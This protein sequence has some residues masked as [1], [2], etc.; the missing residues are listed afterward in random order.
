MKS[1]CVYD[2][3]Y[4]YIHRLHKLNQIKAC[5]YTDV[6]FHWLPKINGITVNCIPYLET[7][8]S[9]A[10]QVTGHSAYL[11]RRTSGYI[12]ILKYKSIIFLILTCHSRSPDNSLCYLTPIIEKL[13]NNYLNSWTSR[14]FNPLKNVNFISSFRP[15]YGPGVDLVSNRNE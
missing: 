14:N 10:I 12:I 15:R 5:R 7:P 8:S 4:I 9:N 13:I 1:I 6:W 3:I 11:S 2:F